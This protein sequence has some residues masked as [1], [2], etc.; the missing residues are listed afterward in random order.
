MSQKRRQPNRRSTSGTSRPAPVRSVAGE[1]DA[2][3]STVSKL[4]HLLRNPI[5]LIV[6]TV[7]LLGGVWA[8]QAKVAHAEGIDGSVPVAPVLE[9]PL[10]EAP[11]AE[12]TESVGFKGRLGKAWS[13]LNGDPSEIVAEADADVEARLAQIEILEK[14]TA[15]ESAHLRELM[16]EVEQIK[17][18]NQARQSALVETRSALVSCVNA[19]IKEGQ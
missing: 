3:P 16:D 14:Q 17:A 8:F 9:E 18:E 15:E 11:V 13:Y 19:A 1:A 6:G 10:T 7:I 12:P 4:F 5:G 2:R